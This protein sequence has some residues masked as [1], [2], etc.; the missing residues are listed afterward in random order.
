VAIFH[1]IDGERY[2]YAL[3]MFMCDLKAMKSRRL[4]LESTV[5]IRCL[6]PAAQANGG[7]KTASVRFMKM[8]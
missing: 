6:Q 1:R 2:H 7:T 3:G 5:R 8:N 4:I